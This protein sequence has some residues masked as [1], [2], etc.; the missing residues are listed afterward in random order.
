MRNRGRGDDHWEMCERCSCSRERHIRDGEYHLMLP[1]RC[2][3]KDRC[4]AELMH[5]FDYTPWAAM[6]ALGR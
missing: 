4:E 3:D 5:G 2:D 6:K 1:S